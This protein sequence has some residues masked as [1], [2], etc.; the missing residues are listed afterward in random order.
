MSRSRHSEGCAAAAQWSAEQ[1]AHR[2]STRNT[3]TGA[4]AAAVYVPARLGLMGDAVRMMRVLVRRTP[5]V[6][7]H[8]VPLK[9]VRASCVTG[10]EVR[11]QPVLTGPPVR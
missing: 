11:S 2:A 4:V 9:K 8:T 7:V 6:I 1:P 3:G 5:T 10:R